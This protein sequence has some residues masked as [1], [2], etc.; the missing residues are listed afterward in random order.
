MP[1]F[2]QLMTEPELEQN[3]SDTNTIHY[4][5]NC[6]IL[7]RSIGIWREIKLLANSVILPGESQGRGAGGPSWA[8]VSG[9]GR[10]ESDT[11]EAT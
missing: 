6:I 11:T 5:L 10:T 4:C 9:V 3:F 1:K 8:T 2:T 7:G